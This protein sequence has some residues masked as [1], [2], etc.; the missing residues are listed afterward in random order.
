MPEEN[1]NFLLSSP[2]FFPFELLLQEDLLLRNLTPPTSSSKI[3]PSFHVKPSSGAF[4]IK[5]LEGKELWFSFPFFLLRLR[6]RLQVKI[7]VTSGKE[8]FSEK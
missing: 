4:R 8:L 1:T 3:L 5:S 2:L 6:C 7:F